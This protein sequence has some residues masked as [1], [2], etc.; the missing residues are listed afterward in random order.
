M[1]PVRVRASVLAVAAAAVAAL[2]ASASAGA[3]SLGGGRAGGKLIAAGRA[4]PDAVS[5]GAGGTIMS[6]RDLA[7][8][9]A[10]V[11]RFDAAGAPA[12]DQGI[13]F[14]DAS[15]VQLASDGDGGAVVAVQH[16][17][18]AVM[19]VGRILHAGATTW[20]ATFPVGAL[21]SGGDGGAWVISQSGEIFADGIDPA[22]SLRPRL[23][24]TASTDSESLPVA[25]GDGDGGAYLA[26]RA[27]ASETQFALRL[28]HLSSDGTLWDAPAEVA[29]SS[30]PSMTPRLALDGRGG[31]IVS[32]HAAGFLWIHD[33][34]S[35]GAPVWDSV[36]TIPATADTVSA[37]AADDGAVFV[38][39]SRRL[40]AAPLPVDLLHIS[41]IGTAGALHWTRNV[42]SVDGGVLDLRLIAGDRAATVAWQSASLP[43]AGPALDPDLF[44][45]RV[46][47]GGAETYPPHLRTL[48]DSL[49]PESLGAL[50]DGGAG[51][52]V[53]VF[54]QTPCFRGDVSGVAMQR[55]GPSGARAFAADGACP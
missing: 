45:Y 46:T 6:S 53:A 49:G 11:N 37:V 26:W 30:E 52:V 8:G 3:F 21:V 42:A 50:V 29:G 12:W 28:Q 35:D 48:A 22:G 20:Q 31:V 51:L 47:A 27:A 5:D 25:L 4:A 32:W 36:A 14:P 1:R 2:F 16:P 54:T 55:I 43:V 40:R 23:Q 44:V 38:A 13:S 41:F 39:W 24:V 19:T 34:S 9:I 15:G 18:S 33:Y 10:V 7:G 17:D